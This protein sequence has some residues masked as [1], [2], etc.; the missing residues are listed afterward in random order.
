MHNLHLTNCGC[1]QRADGTDY[2]RI[3]GVEG[4][5]E[6]GGRRKEKDGKIGRRGVDTMGLQQ[7]LLQ[8]NKYQLFFLV[9]FF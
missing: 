9:I 1:T 5:K 3:G 2:E 8:A 7:H 6:G 4:G